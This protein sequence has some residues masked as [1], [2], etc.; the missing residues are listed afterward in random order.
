MHC[1]KAILLA[2]MVLGSSVATAQSTSGSSSGGQ[3][4][5]TKDDAL[6]ALGFTGIKI[7]RYTHNHPD[8]P[9]D[10]RLLDVRTGPQVPIARISI[11][12]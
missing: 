8:N 5:F 12:W 1:K 2:L 7:V 9:V 10:K 11:A 6:L 3:P 4:L